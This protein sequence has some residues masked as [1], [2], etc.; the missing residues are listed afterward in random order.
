MH[1]C[2][3]NP[4]SLKVRRYAARF[5]DLHEYLAS[6]PGSTTSDRMGVTELNDILLNII[7]NICSNFFYVQGFDYDFFSFQRAV[8]MFER[9]EIAESIYECVVTPSYKKTTWAETNC[10]GISRNK[11]GE[12]ALSK[13]HRT[14]DEIAGKRNKRYVDRLKSASKH[15]MIHELGYSSDKCKFLGEFGTK[16]VVARHTKDRG[17]NPI[18]KRGFQKKQ[19]NHIIID[20]MVDEFHR[21]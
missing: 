14:K 8:N 2:I 10:T 21:V 18:P 5:I 7:S 16:Y 1:L 13:T 3:K 12:A 6:F 20:N 19:E 9:M 4:C 15:C 11:R 17:S